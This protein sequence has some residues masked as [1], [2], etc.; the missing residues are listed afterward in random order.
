MA[1]QTKSLTINGRAFTLTYSDS[2]RYVVRDGV[3]YVEAYD[4]SEFGRV[5]TEGNEI[6]IDESAEMEDKAKAF[7]I[8]MGEAE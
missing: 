8:L 7:D 5:Y 2:N 1:I 6:P 3:E 4:P